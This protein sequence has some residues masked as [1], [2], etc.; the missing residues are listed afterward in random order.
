MANKCTNDRKLVAT[1]T[2]KVSKASDNN[3]TRASASTTTTLPSS[4]SS[5][6]AASI[7]TGPADA[8]GVCI[9]TEREAGKSD[10]ACSGTS[11]AQQTSS[12]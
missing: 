10:S 4:S 1:T 9:V 7:T 2:N 12:E 8:A 3:T 11:T 5:S 6:A